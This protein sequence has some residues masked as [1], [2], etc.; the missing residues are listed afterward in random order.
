MSIPLTYV[1]PVH[2]AQAWLQRKVEELLDDL[3]EQ[4]DSFELLIIDD[5]SLDDTPQVAHQLSTKYPQITFVRRQS[6]FGTD[7]ALQMALRQAKGQR[8]VL[9][10]NASQPAAGGREFRRIELAGKQPQ[11]QL[12]APHFRLAPTATRDITKS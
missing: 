3:A 5:G 11:P 12:G 10:V 8:V 2:D 6:R 4:T 9:V 7:A 1:L